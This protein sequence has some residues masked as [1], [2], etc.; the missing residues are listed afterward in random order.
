MS[1]GGNAPMVF[2]TL[3][4]GQCF[5]DLIEFSPRMT[6]KGPLIEQL[7]DKTLGQGWY[8]GTAHGSIVHEGGGLQ[9]MHQVA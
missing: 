6:T 4:K 9:G 3:P 1:H 8:L 2:N 5:R 7:M